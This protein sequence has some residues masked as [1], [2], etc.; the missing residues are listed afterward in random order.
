MLKEATMTV[1]LELPPEIGATL[2][3]QAEA[4]GLSLD[5]F[6][7]VIIATQAA[8]MES[9]SSAQPLPR[10]VEDLDRAIDELFDAVHVPPGVGEG[11]LRRENWY[12]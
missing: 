10:E 9:M 4:R 1:T 6:L 7:R 3:S 5:A 2:A 11:A 8:A 12:R